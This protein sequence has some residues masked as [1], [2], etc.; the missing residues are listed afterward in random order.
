MNAGG[1]QPTD[2]MV[3]NIPVPDECRCV[4]AASR[5]VGP[6]GGGLLCLR[7]CS[8]GLPTGCLG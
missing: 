2:R 7:A 4:L 1:Y 8:D 5:M 3:F 6:R